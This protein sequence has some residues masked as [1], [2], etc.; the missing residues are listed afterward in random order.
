MHF[1]HTALP[2][3]NRQDIEIGKDIPVSDSW[4]RV[5]AVIPIS[6]SLGVFLVLYLTVEDVA[7]LHFCLL[8]RGLSALVIR[9]LRPR[10]S[11]LAYFSSPKELI[12]TI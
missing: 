2:R 12:D 11:S 6:Y 1:P 4:E 5:L 9:A 7:E 3:C 8:P 10:A